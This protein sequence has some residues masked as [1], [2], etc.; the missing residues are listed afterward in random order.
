MKLF[1][2]A[3]RPKSRLRGIWIMAASRI[4]SSRWRFR[5]GLGEGRGDVRS[6]V[7]EPLAVLGRRGAVAPLA[8]ELQ[9]QGQELAKQGRAEGRGGVAQQILEAAPAARLPCRLEA[10]AVCDNLVEVRLRQ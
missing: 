4:E 3:R 6:A 1:C 9:L 5:R 7:G 10:V 8:A 2:R